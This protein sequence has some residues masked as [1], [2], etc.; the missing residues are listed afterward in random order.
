MFGED[1]E[2]CREKVKNILA[3]RKDLLEYEMSLKNKSF[4]N[5]I[6]RTSIGRR[7]RE[8]ERKR[9]ERDEKADIFAKGISSMKKENLVGMS[10][11]ENQT[12]NSRFRSMI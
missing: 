10:N 12:S 11:S 8:L 6:E 5:R 7:M 4:R 3:G 1:A 9:I 2:V